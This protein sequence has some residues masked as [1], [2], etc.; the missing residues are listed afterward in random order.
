MRLAVIT[1]VGPGHQKFAADA[2]ESVR[3]AQK[4]A[5]LFSSVRHLVIDDGNGELGRGR[6]RN[7]GM[8]DDADWYF[9][10]DADD[11]MRP[12]ALNIASFEAQAIFG[13]ISLSS[14]RRRVK[15]VSPCGWRE[16]ALYG[17]GGTLSMGFFCRADVARRLKF[18]EAM[19]A[20]EDFDFYLRLDE[21]CKIDRPL[22]DIGYGLPSAGGPRGYVEIDW[23]GICNALIIEAVAKEPAKY[24]LRGDAILAK[25]SDPRSF[26]CDIS[27]PLPA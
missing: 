15:N 8:V 19:D 13:A 26:A 20:G 11:L 10:L 7:L 4:N 16:I 17:A 22:V 23:T 5:G 14:Y 27:E 18:D 25:A 12:D 1:P 6:A 21:F 24:D 2:I 3:V 9:F